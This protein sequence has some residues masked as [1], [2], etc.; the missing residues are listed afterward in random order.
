[1]FSNFGEA[2]FICPFVSSLGQWFSTWSDLVSWGRLT[3][4][5]DISGC[6]MGFGGRG[7]GCATGT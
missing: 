7:E 6:H 3:V 4:S 2:K 1:M 5:G